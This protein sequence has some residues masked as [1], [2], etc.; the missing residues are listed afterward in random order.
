MVRT[1]SPQELEDVRLTEAAVDRRPAPVKAAG[2]ALKPPEGFVKLY[3]ERRSN[4]K[5]GDAS[6]QLVGDQSDHLIV[7]GMVEAHVAIV[8]EGHPLIPALMRRHPHIVMLRHDEEPGRVYNCEACDDD[9]PSKRA[10][11]IHRKDVHAPPDEKQAAAS[12]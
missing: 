1:L 6:Q 3:D 5:F 10:L 12:A 9:F 7:F 2:T 8:R 11:T 4:L